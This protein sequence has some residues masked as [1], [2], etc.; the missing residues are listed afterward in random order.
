M[1]CPKKRLSPVFNE[2]M[3][4]NI[5]LSLSVSDY[6]ELEYYIIRKLMGKCILRNMHSFTNSTIFPKSASILFV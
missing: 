1:S 3:K 2:L 5:T 6:F 4:A